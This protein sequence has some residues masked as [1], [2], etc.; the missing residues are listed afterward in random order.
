[1]I[2]VQGNVPRGTFLCEN[3]RGVHKMFHVEQFL[4]AFFNFFAEN[5]LFFL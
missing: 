2:D 1:M 5:P 4:N 3:I